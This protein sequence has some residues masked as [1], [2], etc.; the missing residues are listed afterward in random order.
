MSGMSDKMSLV[1]VGGI[2]SFVKNWY[3]GYRGA[4]VE[5]Y[6]GATDRAN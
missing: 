3:R 5:G 4:F 6:R 2:T 1:L